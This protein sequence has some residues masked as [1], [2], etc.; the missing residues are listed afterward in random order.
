[1]GASLLHLLVATVSFVVS[2]FVMSGTLRGMLLSR[3]GEQMFLL[4]Y[5]FISIGT[6]AWVIV[7]FDRTDPGFALWNG[8]HPLPWALASLLTIA[9]LAFL[10]PSFVR[11]PALPGKNAAGLGTVIPSGVFKITRHP[12]MWGIALWALAHLIAAPTAR[13]IILMVGLI[14]LALVGSRLQDKRKLARNKREFQPW[15]RRTS[16]WPQTSQF[17]AIGVIWIIAFLV[18]FLITWAHYHFFGI[19]AGLW[20]WVR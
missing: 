12:M 1:M 3:L 18:W 7:V 11:N 14:V 13:S 6:L 16:F 10:I 4:V 19:P 9:A 20:L 15:Q 8:M 17:G 5:S 2:H